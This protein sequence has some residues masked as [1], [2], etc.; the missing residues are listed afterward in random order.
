MPMEFERLNLFHNNHEKKIEDIWSNDAPE[1]A[2]TYNSRS[3]KNTNFFQFTHVQF[4]KKYLRIQA[5][6]VSMNP[7]EIFLITIV[8]SLNIKKHHKT[9][10]TYE[11]VCNFLRSLVCN[12]AIIDAKI[13]PI[14]A[15]QF[16]LPP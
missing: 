13:H 14:L 12:F 2:K 5:D 16:D 6:F 1:S 3:L 7:K 10:Q 11:R 9:K 8:F 4:G 15:A